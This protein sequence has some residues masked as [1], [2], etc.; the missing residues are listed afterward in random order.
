MIKLLDEESSED[1]DDCMQLVLPG[2]NK[3]SDSDAGK[4]I[5]ARYDEQAKV[6]GF[7]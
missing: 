5:T 6:N 3:M 2:T 4:N 7:L 1:N